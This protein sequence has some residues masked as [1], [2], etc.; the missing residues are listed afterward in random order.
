MPARVETGLGAPGCGL[1]G[2][3]PHYASDTRHFGLIQRKTYIHCALWQF[4]VSG[5]LR[6][7]PDADGSHRSG[8]W[9]SVGEV[10]GSSRH[11]EMRKSSALAGVLSSGR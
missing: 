1:S 9:Q 11:F 7:C 10:S 5:E 8:P 6:H 4:I 3:R 2:F